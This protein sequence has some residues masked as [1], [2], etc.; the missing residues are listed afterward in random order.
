MGKKYPCMEVDLKKLTHN[1]KTILAMCNKKHID[2]AAVTKVYCAKKPIVEAI[3][4]AGVAMVADSRILNL[5]KLNDLN[6]KKMLLRIPMISE[7]YE[8]V[9]YSDCSLNSEIDTIEQLAKASNKLNKIHSIILM[10]DLGDLREGVLINDVVSLVSKIVK[11][12][13]IKLIGLG[14]N[15]TCYG[16]VIPDSENLG[17]LIKLKLEI[18]KTFDLKLPVIS[19]GNSSS[20][21]MVINDNMPKEINQLRIGEAIVLGRETS[22]GKPVPNCYDDAFILSGEIVEIKSKPTVP[23]GTIGMDAFGYIPSFEDKGIR[24]RAII[25]LGRQD[26]RVE[27][28]TPLDNDISI[29]GA[30]S[31][32]LI[33]DVTDSKKQLIVGSIVEFKIDY[34]CLLKA[35]TS[36]YVEKYYNN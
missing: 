3:L 21:Y 30:S 6:C 7:A 35:M 27:G 13:N 1:V 2:V 15:V 26:I 12:D 10:V 22:F 33:L 36:P 11:L 23:T 34:G 8:V 25:A 29:F 24:K 9:K 18:E 31:D 5:K 19:G 4:E 17:K 14:T 16:G 20:L 32:H 28:I